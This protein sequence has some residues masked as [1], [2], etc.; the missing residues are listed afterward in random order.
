MEVQYS[1]L[2]STSQAQLHV[3]RET[4]MKLSQCNTYIKNLKMEV[5]DLGREKEAWEEN[6]AQIKDLVEENLLLEEKVAN[7]C[8]LP[9]A[10]DDSSK[11]EDSNQIVQLQEMEKELTFYKNQI[12]VKEAKVGDLG[13]QNDA[14]AS[15]CIELQSI[16]DRLQHEEDSDC[17]GN[18]AQN[19]KGTFITDNVAADDRSHSIHGENSTDTILDPPGSEVRTLKALSRQHKKHK[20]YNSML[21]RA[22]SN[23]TA[24]DQYLRLANNQLIIK[25]LAC[26]LLIEDNFKTMLTVDFFH[27]EIRGSNIVDG[28]SVPSYQL[29]VLYKLAAID[30]WTAGDIVFEFYTIEGIST[31]LIGFCS[32]KSRSVHGGDKIHEISIKSPSCIDNNLGFLYISSSMTTHKLDVAA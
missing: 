20:G 9:F 1:T 4:R 31:E 25:V 5:H 15:R 32:L 17:N 22:R 21:G 16:I 28:T 13:E 2:H 26:E 6:K 10:Q 8:E 12:E 3:H 7:L 24:K 30:F 11:G 19:L 23:S 14:L 27:F 29:E 18:N